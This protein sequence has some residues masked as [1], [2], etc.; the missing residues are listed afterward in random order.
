MEKPGYSSSYAD[1]ASENP[2]FRKSYDGLFKD[3]RGNDIRQQTS[4]SQLA[5]N[6]VFRTVF[7]PVDY[8]GSM[9]DEVKKQ[10]HSNELGFIIGVSLIGGLLWQ[11]QSFRRNQLSMSKK[12]FVF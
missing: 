2:F 12:R 10:W 1:R 6:I 8:D 9:L 5:R 3:V 4:Y 7:N 11:L